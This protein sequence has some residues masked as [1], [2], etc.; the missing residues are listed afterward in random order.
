M[1]TGVGVGFDTTGSCVGEADA[2]GCSDAP[3]VVARALTGA[4]SV[5]DGI[6]VNVGSSVGT[7]VGANVGVGVS[8]GSGVRVGRIA[9]LVGVGDAVD[10]AVG[11]SVGVAVGVTDPPKGTGVS[12]GTTPIARVI[13]GT[14]IW[15]LVA[16]LIGKD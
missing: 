8:V 3:T 13:V 11:V 4:C 14:V 2:I 15:L 7:S 1:G 16:R 6:G 10:S 12:V 9:V 5:G